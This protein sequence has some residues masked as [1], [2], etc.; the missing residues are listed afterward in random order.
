MFSRAGT[1]LRI[2]FCS[3]SHTSFSPFR[4]VASLRTLFY[5][6]YNPDIASVNWKPP[7]HFFFRDQQTEIPRQ[8]EICALFPLTFQLVY[9]EHRGWCPLRRHFVVHL[10]CLLLKVEGK[11]NSIVV[12]KI[13][14]SLVLVLPAWWKMLTKNTENDSCKM[15]FFD[16]KVS[17]TV[18]YV[19]Y[20]T[21]GVPNNKRA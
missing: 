21:F 16:A 6:T 10:V 18:Q 19:F 5:T 1:Y 15:H 4:T 17:C 12:G 14:A 13:F 20:G 8:L 3:Q 11:K 2:C 7:T 9:R